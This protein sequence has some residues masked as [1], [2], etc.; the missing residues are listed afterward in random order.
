MDIDKLT[1]KSKAALQDAIQQAAAAGNPT[2][3]PLHLLNAL[4]LDQTSLALRLAEAAHAATQAIGAQTRVALAALPAAS[5]ASTG[6]PQVGRQL[7]AALDAAQKLADEQGDS[8]VSAEILLIALAGL[9]GKTGDILR[10]NGASPEALAKQLPEIRGGQTVQSA[11]PE[12]TFDALG[13]YGRDLTEAAK[14]GQLDPVIGR[15]QEIRRVIQVLS[16]RTKNNPVLIGEPGVGKT[17]V[18]EGLA[19]RI[20]KG[21]VPEALRGKQLIALDLGSMVAGAK[22]RGEF[23]ERLKAVLQEIKDSDGQVVTFIDELHTVV[24]AG[25]AEGAMDAGNMLKP[26]LARGELRMVGATTLDEY[27]ERIEKDPALER[28]F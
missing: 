4:W 9:E 15:D 8:Y 26:M 18:V 13:Q 27:R 17:A 22:Y 14:D 16:R 28:R 6:Q 20:V 5:G 3:E 25:A 11:N 24:G 12:G 2:V 1:A 7:L 10:S 23:E 19:Q 21:D